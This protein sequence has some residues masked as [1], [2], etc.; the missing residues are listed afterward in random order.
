MPVAGFDDKAIIVFTD[1]LE[2]TAPMIADVM[3]QIDARTYA[4]GLGDAQQ[5]STSALTG[6]TNGTGGYLLLTGLLGTSTDDFFRLAKY[7]LQILAGVTNASIVVD[8]SGTVPPGVVVRVP[9]GLNEADIEATVI[10]LS[11][12]PVIRLGVESP[13]GDLMDSG[14]AGALGAEYTDAG[15]LRSFRF[16]LPLALGPAG[17]HAGTWQALLEVRPVDLRR[18]L[19]RLKKSAPELAA[20]AQTHGPRYSVI[21]NARSNLK[22]TARLDQDRLTPGA[23]MRPAARLREY[24]LPVSHRSSVVAEVTRPDGQLQPLPLV[25]Q[26]PGVFSAAMTAAMAGSYRFRIVATGASMRGEP[27]TRE[28]TLTGAALPGGDGPLP[29]G[30]PAGQ[31]LCELAT[32]LLEDPRIRRLFEEHHIDP[33]RIRDCF[34]RDR[35]PPPAV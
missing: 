1:G 9:F 10:L 23:T 27:F 29:T 25:E 35:L 26:E 19:A 12:I 30:S 21:V 22:M 13:A 34:C 28:V 14:N 2:N 5:V 7:F 31:R 20:R 33:K 17:A 24:G 16:G 15:T 32:C 3:G 18:A 4:I 6:L 8:P 11:D